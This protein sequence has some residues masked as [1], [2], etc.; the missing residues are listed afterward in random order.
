MSTNEW[1]FLAVFVLAAGA[2]VF[3]A[4]SMQHVRD[5]KTRFRVALLGIFASRHYFDPPGRRFLLRARLCTAAAVA[6]LGVW[7]FI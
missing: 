7:A 3:S 5:P 2:A 4:R 6:V 1:V